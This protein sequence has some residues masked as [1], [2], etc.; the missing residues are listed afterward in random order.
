MPKAAVKLVLSALILAAWAT[1]GAGERHGAIAQY[2]EPIAPL[3]AIEG[4]DPRMVRLGE[5]LFN[6]P[7]LSRDDTISCAFCH[8]LASGGVDLLPRSLGI[9]GRE[10]VINAP[11]VF[12]AALN[13][14]QFW[15]GRADTLEEQVAG[16]IH[17]PVEMDSDWPSVVAKLSGDPSYREPFREIWPNRGIAAETIAS[18]IAEFERSLITVD[19]PFD[20]WLQGDED[21]ISAEAKEGY[22]LFKSHG[23]ATCHQGANVGGNLYQYMGVMGDY[24]ADR[25]DITQAD[26]GRYNITGDEEDRH[27]FK[28][29]S[30]RMAPH[31]SPYFHDGSAKDLADAI[32]TMARYQLG[33]TV[34]AAE[35]EL[36][37]AFL[38]TLAGDH[39]S[40]APAPASR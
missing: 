12:N 31:T 34:S 24:F 16:P 40:A 9:A 23:C 22:R 7:R 13:F 15:D 5:R 38:A 4:L 6:D 39:H 1:L 35:T 8:R 17:N 32:A 30:L 20:R 2:A 3:R 19:S 10:G 27:L 11:T 26:M 33:H 18:A 28:V 25:G 37:I 21:A 29:P 14:V 36:I